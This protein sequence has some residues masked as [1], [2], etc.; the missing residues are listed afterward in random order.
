MAAAIPVQDL[1]SPYCATVM[2]SWVRLMRD[3]QQ[4]LWK[5]V[6]RLD[7]CLRSERP[8]TSDEGSA[9]QAQSEAVLDA[10]ALEERILY[11]AVPMVEPPDAAVESTTGNDGDLAQWAAS[12]E[13]TTEAPQEQSDSAGHE[14]LEPQAE[15][16]VGSAAQSSEIIFIDTSVEDY[17][18]LLED[19]S[20][21]TDPTRQIEVVFIDPTRD[22]LEQIT[23]ALAG[24]TGIDALHVVSHG[25]EGEVALGNTRLTAESLSLYADHF[26]A[27]N[28]SLSSGA[29]L[30]IYGCDLASSEDG[31]DLVNS[32]AALT[33]ADVA[34][35]E[36]L[37][38]NAELG[39]D[40]I[41]EY[42]VGDI[43]SDVAFGYAAQASWFGTLDVTSGLVAHYDFEENG[44]TTVLDETANDNDG[45]FVNSPTW[46]SDS[47]VGDYSLVFTGDA[48]SSNNIVT[49]PDAPSLDF[50]DE[51]SISFWYN[52]N[53]PQFARGDFLRSFD[54]S[55]GFAVGALTNGYVSFNL[56]GSNGSAAWN[57][58]GGFIPDS[59]WHHV[60]ATFADNT[61][62]IYV[63]NTVTTSSVVN[64]GVIDPA[65][66]ITLGG[67]NGSSNDYDGK[68][69]DVRIY[70]RALAASEVEDLYELPDQT[71]YTVTNTNDSGAGSLRQAIIDA[72]NN[73][74]HDRIEFDIAG[75]GT[76]VITL[77]SALDTIT[78]Q[79]TID[80]TTQTG[81]TEGSFLP[82]VIDGNGI[83]AVG[84]NIDSAA[85]GSEV[86]GLV[87]RDFAS[88]N[89]HIQSGA[90]DV[91]VS[92]N[93]LGAFDSSGNF[94]AGNGGNG[95]GVLVEG[96][97]AVIGGHTIADRN[98]FGGTDNGVV[99]RGDSTVVSGNYFGLNAAGAT[100]VDITFDGVRFES[101]ASGGL[102]GGA[103][104]DYRNFLAGVGDHGI[105]VTGEAT[106][107]TTIS[108]NWLG[109]AANGATLLSIGSSGISVD[110]GADFTQVS[111]NTILATDDVGIRITGS[112]TTNTTITGNFIGT[113]SDKTVAGNIASHGIF[114][115]DSA[116]DTAIGELGNGNTI[117]NVT[118]TDFDGIRLS[119]LAGA[120][121]VIRG[122]SIYG[123]AGLGID[124]GDGG[125][126]ANDAGDS[127]GVQNWAAI[128]QFDIR[129]NGDVD[130]SID[131]TTLTS[132]TY[133][134]D[135]YASSDRDGGAV[136][137]ERYLFSKTIAGNAGVVFFTEAGVTVSEGEYIT[138]VT[139]GGGNSSELSEYI[140]AVSGEAD[141][142][143][144]ADLF[145]FDGN[146]DGTL[147]LND[148]G[149]NNAYLEAVDGGAILGG[150]TELT[151][152][153]NFE[154]THTGGIP[155]LSYATVD[156]HNEML[157]WIDFSGNLTLLHAG[158]KV[159]T[160][161]YD[162]HSLS[163]GGRHSIAVALDTNTGQ[164][165]VFVNGASVAT[166]S[167]LP[168]T[169]VVGEG[170]LVFGQELD[171]FYGVF[172]P[173]QVFKGRY[174]SIQIYDHLRTESEALDAHRYGVNYD[175]AGLVAQ[176]TFDGI[177]TEG[178]VK[179]RVAGTNHLSLEHTSESGFT[180][181]E[182]T[183]GFSVWENADDGS[184]VGTVAALDADREAR[185]AELVA[186]EPNLVYSAETGKF[187]MFSSSST[188]FSTAQSNAV[189]TL[190]NGASGQLATITSA[191]EQEI[192]QSIVAAEGTSIWLGA[193][194]SA[195]EGEWRW[196]DGSS[197]GD[198]FWQGD[199]GGTAVNGAYQNWAS[200]EP[201]DNSG[202]DF[203]IMYATGG[204]AGQ[205][206]DKGSGNYRSVIEWDVDDVL[207]TTDA[208]TFTLQ[209]QS[210]AGAFAIDADT[211]RLTVADSSLL[212]FNTSVSET[213]S[214]LATDSEGN[215][216]TE[217]FTVSV[218]N[219][220]AT[221]TS[222][223]DIIVGTNGDDNVNG[224]AGNDILLGGT[225]L[226]GNGNFNSDTGL[227]QYGVTGTNSGWTIS[228]GSVDFLGIDEEELLR[229]TDAND[230]ELRAVDLKDA[231]IGQTLG[232]LTIGETYH[233]AFMLGADGETTQ[234]VNVSTDGTTA[235]TEAISVT[236]PSGNSLSNMN[237]QPRV[238][239]F[240]ATAATHTL[241]FASVTG[242]ASGGPLIAGVR[243]VS[244]SVTNG[245]DILRGGDG[246]DTIIGGGEE[247][248]LYGDAGN[249]TVYGGEGDDDIY[250]G[251]GLD[252]LFG[253]S[254]ADRFFTSIDGETDLI[255]GGEDA[256]LYR[257][258]NDTV[259]D[260]IRDSG[261]TG[262][263]IIRAFS[264]SGSFT[265]ED[266]FSLALTGIEQVRGF[267]SSNQNDLG[268]ASHSSALHW[269]FTGVDLQYILELHGSTQNDTI[270]VDDTENMDIFG[271]GGDD[272][273]I[274][275]ANGHDLYG[276]DG[277]DSL[278]GG[279]G[280]D[281]LYGDAGFDTA[282]YDGNIADYSISRSIYHGN[283]NSGYLRVEETNVTG[284]DEDQ[285]RVYGTVERIVFADAVYDTATASVTALPSPVLDNTGD[286]ALDGITTS[287][288]D[289][290]GQTV[291]SVIASAGGDRITDASPGAV[292]GIAITA[293]NDGNGHWE[294]S[295]DSGSSWID[296]DA[297]SGTASLLLRETD[298][299]R[300]VPNGTTVTTADISFRAWDQTSGSA[301]QK[302]DT[303]TNGGVTAF[304]TATENATIEV[305]LPNQAPSFGIGDGIV[306]TPVGDTSEGNG[307]AVQLDGKI[308]VVG[309]TT[310]S[311]DD[312][313]L[314]RYNAD[315][316]L[317]TSFGGGDGIVITDID[318]ADQEGVDVRIQPDGKIVVASNR[319]SSGVFELVRYEA[320][321]SLDTSFG[322]GG[323][324]TTQFTGGTD[325]QAEAL[326]IQDDGKILVGGTHESASGTEYAVA[327]Y[328]SNGSLDTSFSGDGMQT[329]NTGNSDIVYGMT[330]QP[331]GKILLAGQSTGDSLDF[332][333]ARINADG[334]VDT[335]FGAGNGYVKHDFNSL[336]DLASSITV[337]PD[338]KILVAGRAVDTNFDFALLQL[339]S[340]GSVDT[341][342]G[343]G[344]GWV[345]TDATGADFERV[346][347]LLLDDDGKVTVVGH[348]TISSDSDLIAIRYLA[349]GSLDASFGTAG[350]AEIDLSGTNDRAYAA[351][352]QGDGKIV[353]TGETFD[354]AN[355][356]F[357]LRLDAD[358]ALDERF[359]LVST[360][361][362]SPT[363][364]ENGSPVVLDGNVEIFDAELSDADDF[365]GATLTL[366]R[367][368]GANSDDVFSATGSLVFDDGTLEL[369]STEIGS[370]AN[371][372]G[373]LTITFAAG[374]S[375]SQVNDA[376]QLI[377]YSNSNDT[378]PSGVTLEWTFNDND[379]RGGMTAVETQSV[380]ISS[381]N[382]DPDATGVPTDVTVTED[383]L[384]NL[385][386]S[387]INFSDADAGSS[388]LTVT[389]STS[390]GGNLSATSDGGVTVGGTATSRTFSGTLANLNAYFNDAS[391][392][393]Y[394]HPASHTTGNNAD[395]VT[396]VI[397]DGG[398][399]GVGGGT[400][401]TLGVVNVDITNVNDA[402]TGLPT[403]TG[404]V[405]EDQTLT[406][407]TSGISDN[408]GLGT[409]TYQWLRD[410]SAIT[411]ATSSTYTLGDDDV[412]KK[413]SVQVSY[414]DAEGASE[415]PLTSAQTANVVNVNDAPVLDNS[416][417][418]AL[419]SITEDDAGNSGMTVAA[420][421]A[422]GAGGDPIAD[423][424]GPAEGIAITSRNNSQ[425]TWQYSL[426]GGTN[427]SNVGLTSTTNAQLLRST[428]LIRFNPNGEQGSAPS[429][430]FRAWDQS[431]GTAGS[432]VDVSTNG[433][434][435]AFSSE[436][437]TATIVVT[438]V[439][440]APTG[441]VTISGT[442]TE[443]ETLTAINTI[444]DADG[445][446]TISYQWQRNG[447]DISGA[448][449]STYTLGDA[450]VG[451]AIRVVASYTDGNGTDETVT[452]AATSAITNVNDTPT[453]SV[454]ISGTATENQTLTA[455]NT[456]ADADGLGTITYQWQRDGV[457]IAGA[458]GSTYTLG[459]ADVGA[460][461]RVVASYTDS[462]GTDETVTSAATSAITNVNDTPS[463][464]PTIS[465]TATENQTLTADISGISDDDGLGTFSYQWLRDGSAISGATTSNYTLGDADVGARISVQVS[466]VDGNGTSEGPLTSSQTVNIVNVN[467][468]PSGTPVINGFASEDQ[469]LTADTSGIS[470]ND[471]LGTFSYQWLRD[472]VNVSGATGGTYTLTDSDVGSVISVQVSYSDANGTSEMVSSSG[473]GPIANTNDLPTAGLRATATVVEDV[474][475]DLDLLAVDITDDDHPTGT[476]ILTVKL[477]TST[478][479]QI[480]ASNAA[481]ITVAGTGSSEVS[482]TGTANDINNYLNDPAN[483]RYLHSTENRQGAGADSIA[484]TANDNEGSGDVS[485]GSVAVD[486]LAVNDAPTATSMT[487]EVQQGQNAI[488]TADEGLLAGAA[489][490]DGDSLSAVLIAGP[491]MGNLEFEADGSWAY[492][493]STQFVSQVSFEF[494][495]T[496]GSDNSAVQTVTIDITP[497][498][499][500]ATS[501]STSDPTNDHTSD[502]EPGVDSQDDTDMVDSVEPS[503]DAPVEELSTEPTE[504]EYKTSREA[505]GRSS[506]QKRA[507]ARTIDALTVVAQEV[508]LN[509]F[510]ATNNTP[511]E[512]NVISSTFTLDGSRQRSYSEQLFY[513][514]ERSKLKFEQHLNVQQQAML[515]FQEQ[516]EE[517]NRAT[518]IQV[519]TAASIFVGATAGVAAWS[520]SGTYLASMAFSAAPA[521][522]RIDPIFVVQQTA[523]KDEDDTSV[524]DIITRQNQSTP[525]G[526]SESS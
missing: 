7:H 119:S 274:D 256:D 210:A 517:T 410:G 489:D 163:D 295:L 443:N 381:R 490:I 345:T 353:I 114:V 354:G 526:A 459:D 498:A 182:I 122:N 198:Q 73:A 136:E 454:T 79:V 242:D 54:G 133:T 411:G 484:V 369:A 181:S 427:W 231:T 43:S 308:V 357:T 446:G 127:D 298:L 88:D 364:I 378:P 376:M 431:T 439:N 276:G 341:S 451:A 389:L 66:P 398:N 30:L 267:G 63:D 388:S 310:D 14:T 95:A 330:V 199:D 351:V 41:L 190:L 129:D 109:V 361:D 100:Q 394:L 132:G 286:M 75:S 179:E 61:L 482:L 395:T 466:Y 473:V 11:S 372:G 333:I 385:D 197:T 367:S 425:G 418:P 203:A 272:T 107:N 277:D 191:A 314:L 343:G 104:E 434:S 213:V 70:S 269:D 113:N 77:S 334:S 415:G 65:A 318:S 103:T 214:I 143:G 10:I 234:T 207:D 147:S 380:T 175:E 316:T 115:S 337:R 399:T 34:A 309:E 524:A 249:D 362:S 4:L 412:G 300:F 29:D 305:T 202:E 252:R 424:D 116:S 386:L 250:D 519:G 40:W 421:L 258:S 237:W 134:V 37:T 428:D 185:I 84:I 270:I 397:N 507:S 457:D 406:A 227:S 323:I 448:T 438:D 155:L 525:E 215:T 91:E 408:D 22:G 226:L 349:D 390:N 211:G 445:L 158:I 165:E 118:S 327:R 420:L 502:P 222:N 224:G 243:M 500:P 68:L 455:S 31:R 485:L 254:G 292:E 521:W 24:R 2:H 375:N 189:G 506:V 450:D 13:N 195:V 248:R 348:G 444:A 96:D 142:S 183:G 225:D 83:N 74:G 260:Q 161:G 433:G 391:N 370:Y 59:A 101:G 146:G 291:A 373:T 508:V 86:S 371:T 236:T 324:V 339:N 393:Q 368:G 503:S 16:S 511:T 440:D 45:S 488:I 463:G 152:E 106:D 355:T 209:A 496:D 313:V 230:A 36:D 60:V 257:A 154:T 98:I 255:D 426:D 494:V 174:H 462:N 99:S 193:S 495:V 306:V 123:N 374:T 481:G 157:I 441:S 442:A 432:L 76:Q 458:T 259:G 176:W 105:Q 307:I 404:T 117:T 180:A 188:G 284:V 1:H 205:W 328:N 201:N 501:S 279:D 150:L 35:S 283:T 212:D 301:G 47:K 359:D 108:H 220:Y 499:A 294:Y 90:N 251:D 417:S 69:D 89:I 460:A 186:G 278:Y 360:I 273:L 82:I 232:G 240:T 264:S 416:G 81:W 125:A 53:T 382:D 296:V 366:H 293:A 169:P 436:S 111:N 340:D 363:F 493:P 216:R 423:P 392:I 262:F 403:I 456:I 164:F 282:Y 170:R 419:T 486:I 468:A 17:Q 325:D 172:D 92:G 504:E 402:P 102:I 162:F 149:G 304:S 6:T 229:P 346:T 206:D 350:T 141:G 38:G 479:G 509:E 435:T 332:T 379:A 58:V 139:T 64:V 121:N 15:L 513:E 358:G 151:F 281:Y 159:V 476:G 177:S 130:V 184:Y 321:G 196:Y 126:T 472:G 110:S 39:G 469:T 322:T 120:N 487:V 52:T 137:A 204:S 128:D 311:G 377:A 320:S 228:G 299:L 167:G 239:T 352:L 50:S 288:T 492:T 280:N 46:S 271:N 94:V 275:G 221:T 266:T 261:T 112:S 145:A 365:E 67:V 422:T 5:I 491:E 400:D 461:I 33:N 51:F 32:L 384:S 140:V 19:I 219:A 401:Q 20:S 512:L 447:V 287:E 138:A 302:V 200:N 72:N 289:N 315:G 97:N 56:Y 144:I 319:Q 218:I 8:R 168:T 235:G 233:V 483:L 3:K 87:I 429:I 297:V 148:D 342:F 246:D 48:S 522:M 62:S 523:S 80:G 335:S 326:H 135:F 27:W 131:T 480:D 241:S 173:S 166:A 49:I 317:D 156:N 387:A 265:I 263:D 21:L 383:V 356:L 396:V 407:D 453:G 336:N 331:D 474:L 85:D 285:D 187:Y 477:A 18:T 464:V 478:G 93:F 268:N 514:E 26:A 413:I 303:S 153:I 347:G 247:D 312:V 449:S 171:A 520:I 245:E 465:G 329:I 223:D 55:T 238:Y 25:S 244:D 194:D 208:I 71:V 510:A 217:T 470:D 344:D 28:A 12:E 518:R 475:S 409:F 44:G 124:N 471:G 338:G 467:D 78:D 42:T 516:Q 253:G 290:D 452:S 192:V 437:E 160:S 497:I 178:F 57:S 505:G 9:A 414:T 430:Q 515:D 23:E 405:T